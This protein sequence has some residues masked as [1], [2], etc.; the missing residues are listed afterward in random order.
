MTVEIPESHRDLLQRPIYAVLTTMLPSGQPQSSLVWWD[1]DGEHVL[2]STTL[3][4]RKSRNM[5]A[6]PKV[7]VLVI[8]PANS[9]RYVEVRGEVVEM[10]QNGA[11]ELAD[12]LTQ[13]YTGKQR[14]YGDVYPVERQAQ[15]TRVVCRIRPS[16]VNAD[17]IFG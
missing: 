6:N 13:R 1:Y 11:V 4:R 2:I 17:A 16:K 8:D 15:E 9:A 3:E 12:R 5:L 7:T 10:S 14:F